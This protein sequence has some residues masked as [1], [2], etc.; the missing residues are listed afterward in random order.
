MKLSALL[1]ISLLA[2]LITVFGFSSPARAAPSI[3]LDLLLN[4]LEKD[5][6]RPEAKRKIHSI[7]DVL[8]TLPESYRR[9]FTL[10]WGSRSLHQSDRKSP[11]VIMFGP[12]ASF[13]IT[14]N[15]DP[16]QKGFDDLEV[17]QYR[18]DKKIFEFREISFPRDHLSAPLVSKANPSKCANCHAGNAEMFGLKPLWSHYPNWPGMYGAKEDQE[19][20]ETMVDGKKELSD[21][22]KFQLGK[23]DHPRYKYLPGEGLFPYTDQGRV[24]LDVRPNARLTNLL[25][26]YNDERMAAILEKAHEIKFSLASAYRSIDAG[27]SCSRQFPDEV[28]IAETED[29]ESLASKTYK[30]LGMTDKD[31]LFE[32]GTSLAQVGVHTGSG[33]AFLMSIEGKI[34]FN[35]LK[36]R[37]STSEFKI[38]E[39]N[40]LAGLTQSLYNSRVYSPEFR[41]ALVEGAAPLGLVV[42]SLAWAYQEDKSS[43]AGQLYKKVCTLIAARLRAMKAE[44]D[45][46][47]QKPAP[48]VTSIIQKSA[49]D[50]NRLPVS[51]LLIKRCA[52]CHV[53]YG[54]P[55]APRIPFDD[56][57]NLKKSGMIESVMNRLNTPDAKL[58]MPRDLRDFSDPEWLQDKKEIEA[59]L[60]DLSEK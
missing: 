26:R 43:S 46:T 12:D 16:A 20:L 17:M 47:E 54:D 44:T 19:S 28:A 31:L 41:Q 42:G 22:G 15:G 4:L 36:S 25:N 56:P 7:E 45:Y 59:Y 8:A 14:F 2:S 29:F 57:M 39:K 18:K 24:N 37:L 48:T 34:V 27:T 40:I 21:F 11:R 5:A 60:K 13:I 58:R 35:W 53:D 9:G 6:S 50:L 30:K 1:V 23:K 55:L 3:N 38:I 51:E 49:S 32:P 33:S 52:H 10:A